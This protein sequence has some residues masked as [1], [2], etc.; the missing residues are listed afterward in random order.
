MGITATP[1]SGGCEWRGKPEEMRR[2]DRQDGER[3]TQEITGQ[4]GGVVRK[5]LRN[6]GGQIYRTEKGKP[7]K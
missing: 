6:S 2:A 3:L 7:K 4:K 5:T 1:K